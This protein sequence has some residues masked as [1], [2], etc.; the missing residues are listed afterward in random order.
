LGQ[1]LDLGRR[2]ELVSMDKH[3]EELS[4]GLYEREIDHAATY[5]VHTYSSRPKAAPRSKFLTDAMVALGGMARLADLGLPTASDGDRVRFSCG[6]AH[7]QAV[8]RLFLECAKLPYDA[9]LTPRPLEID[10]PKSGAHMTLTE[11]EGGLY[12]V[13]SS[14]FT[15]IALRNATVIARGLMKLGE[16]DDVGGGISFPCR[17]HHHALAGL[18]LVRAPNVRAAIREAELAAARGVLSAPSAQQE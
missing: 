9:R 2:V 5:L 18:L 7:L 13:R 8:R 3:C 10:D 12:Q 1:T 14:V 6:A 15:E 16:M 17:Q 11:A 4:F